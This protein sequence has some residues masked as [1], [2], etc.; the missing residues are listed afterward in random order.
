MTS[1]NGITPIGRWT[2]YNR[3]L[4]IRPLPA[5][6]CLWSDFDY[7]DHGHKQ[8]IE[9]FELLPWY[10]TTTSN[11]MQNITPQNPPTASLQHYYPP[12]F[13][14]CMFYQSKTHPTVH[15]I[16]SHELQLWYISPSKLLQFSMKTLPMANVGNLVD[17]E[18]FICSW[19]TDHKSWSFLFGI[20]WSIRVS[21]NFS[22]SLFISSMKDTK[23]RLKLRS[24]DAI[25]L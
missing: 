22:E 7:L 11:L 19:T 15:L 9:L 8:P 3:Y 18:P 5:S 23:N 4:S 20:Y 21:T 10:F 1:P 12:N 6:A 14:V 24:V 16:W 17:H 13:N 2:Q 25:T